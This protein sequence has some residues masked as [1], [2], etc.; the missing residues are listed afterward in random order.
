MFPQFDNVSEEGYHGYVPSGQW[1]RDV[2]D[3]FIEEHRMD[4][5]Q[6]M[7]MLTADVIAIDHSYKVMPIFWTSKEMLTICSIADHKT[8]CKING[9][10]TFIGLLTFTN[11][12]GEI[13]GANWV[14]TL[15]HSQFARTCLNKTLAQSLKPPPT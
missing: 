15:A 4:I 9:E 11:G 6:H 5:T 2:Y 10:Q 14:S 12:K 13:Q 3:Q 7:A 1:L 8:R